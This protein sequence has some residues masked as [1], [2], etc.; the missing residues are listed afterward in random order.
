MWLSP[1][2]CVV[3]RHERVYF[4]KSGEGGILVDCGSEATYSEN[5]RMLGEDGVDAGMISGLLV[6]HEHF[7]HIA[8]IGRAKAELGCPVISHRLA[9]PL[10][11]LRRFFQVIAD[12]GQVTNLS[13]RKG[14]YLS[15]LP[16]LV[17]KALG[18]LKGE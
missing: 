14:D 5:M 13:F 7:D 8:A 9:G 3:G 18:R 12:T 11:R 1:E 17:N 15:D 4:L 16:P 2:V 10:V 6:S